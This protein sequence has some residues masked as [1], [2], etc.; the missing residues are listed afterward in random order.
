MSFDP[1]LGAVGKEVDKEGED[2]E[3]EGVYLLFPALSAGW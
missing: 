2:E 1:V 3:R